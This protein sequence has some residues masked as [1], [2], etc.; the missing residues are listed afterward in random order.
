M[1]ISRAFFYLL[2]Q[3]Y[4][5]LGVCPQVLHTACCHMLPLDMLDVFI[6]VTVS[7]V[8]IY[9]YYF[10]AMDMFFFPF[11]GHGKSWNPR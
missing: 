3:A 1:W 6:S 7:S 5:T 9:Y 4:K 8:F 2:A 10:I 11:G